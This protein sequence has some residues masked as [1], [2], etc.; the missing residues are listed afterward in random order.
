MLII[1]ALL[2]I[3]SGGLVLG[4]MRGKAVD[5][6][7]ICRR[8]GFDLTG[9][10]ADSTRCS[11]C[12]ADLSSKK[13][14]RIGHRRRRKSLLTS[15]LALLVP[16]TGFAGV[17]IW[18]DVQD[19]DWLQYAPRRY[20][21]W[22]ASS[23]DP[24]KREPCFTELTDRATAGKFD[25]A[26]WDAVTTA[27]TAFEANPKLPWEVHW[28]MLIQQAGAQHPMSPAVWSGYVDGLVKQLRVGDSTRRRAVTAEFEDLTLDHRAVT[29]AQWD[30]AADAAL[31]FLSDPAHPWEDL[32]AELIVF[33]R[34]SAHLD[35]A[36]W[37]AYVDLTM[38]AA[39]SPDP[40]RRGPALRS[41]AMLANQK[42]VPWDRV[43]QT[44]LDYQAD[45][46]KPW[47]ST[48]GDLLEMRYRLG[49]LSNPQWKRYAAQAWA[50]SIKLEVRPQIR[51]GDSLPFRLT[52][53]PL[54]VGSDPELSLS[55]SDI[56]P[57]WP[58][59]PRVP[60]E[61]DRFQLIRAGLWVD[62][63]TGK[64]RWPHLPAAMK[65]GV[66]KFD[67]V[68]WVR[69]GPRE[70]RSRRG[71]LLPDEKIALPVSFTLL[72]ADAPSAISEPHA[73]A[74]IQAAITAKAVSAG[75]TP[76]RCYLELH[77][78][79]PPAGLSFH[80]FVRDADGEIAVGDLACPKAGSAYQALPW[81]PAKPPG[82]TVDVI[83]RSDPGP[84]SGTVDVINPWQ[85]KVVLKGVPVEQSSGRFPP[86]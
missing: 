79:S 28:G 72:A 42:N 35:D 71:T 11:E 17:V 85:G 20:L 73:P 37:N 60:A 22:R 23:A 47:D 75:T 74:E 27:A 48:W 21:L 81:F 52:I 76:P 1:L 50:G 31:A 51:A 36:R 9:K 84:A 53:G 54:R 68:I 38:S 57:Q 24:A 82:A 41:L 29:P 39:S 25:T 45:R 67:A 46:S 2:L 30:T 80:V 13:A 65:P 58:G 10:P 3:A 19:V 32:S 63:L 12:G 43:I 59:Q 77:V 33:D 5:D 34:R 26:A 69:V 44:G 15:G 18:N 40:A 8:C 7:P 56:F 64:F 83:L 55:I 86:R 78:N 66:Q 70:G 61:P 16:T 14:V 49:G 4:G 6:H 62:P